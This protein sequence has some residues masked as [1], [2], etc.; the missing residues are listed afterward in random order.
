M[1]KV[2]FKKILSSKSFVITTTVVVVALGFVSVVSAYSSGAFVNIE[3]ASFGDVSLNGDVATDSV[4]SFGATGDSNFTNV[5]TSGYA[6]VGGALT[7]GGAADV[8]GFTQGGGVLSTSTTATAGTLTQSDLASY[9]MIEWTLNT[10]NGTLTLPAT[11]TLTTLLPDAG[12]MRTWLIHNATTTA[13]ITAT[14]A[15]GT[16]I[17]LI[18]VTANDDVIDG[19]EYAELTCWRQSDTDL[20]CLVSELL[21][22]D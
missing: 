21:H 5:V 2:D 6:T 22:A 12:D 8:S 14:I 20:T 11:S 15:A 1:K 10:A 13:A 17:D 4:G 18:A 16:G 19:T 3:N 7:V 9:S